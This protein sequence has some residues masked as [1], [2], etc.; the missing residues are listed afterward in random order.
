MG[1][2]SLT[3]MYSMSRE[4]LMPVLISLI[5]SLP[6]GWIIVEKLLKQFAFRI[7][8]S[9][10]VFAAMAAGAI[11]IAMFTV[12]FQAYKATGI[13]PAQALKVE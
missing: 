8:V 3:I 1:A 6:A 2:G 10:L 5:I 4:F 11:I 12:S 7:D 13:N 9:L